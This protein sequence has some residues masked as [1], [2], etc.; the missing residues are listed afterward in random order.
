MRAPR[1]LLLGVVLGSVVMLSASCD[2]ND[3]DERPL[4]QR[5]P[6]A[7]PLL[8]TYYLTQTT[9]KDMRAIKIPEGDA[10]DKDELTLEFQMAGNEL[11]T[12]VEVGVTVGGGRNPVDYDLY[13]RLISP[14]GTASAWKPVDLATGDIYY[15][16]QIVPFLYEFDGENSTGTWKVQLRDPIKDDDGRLLF[17]N[18]TLRINDGEISTV[19][20][21]ASNA[22][23]TASRDATQGRYDV[24]PEVWTTQ[25]TGDFGYFGVN[26]MLLNQFTFTQSFSVRSLTLSFSLLQRE[27]A[28]DEDMIFLVMSPSGNYSFYQLGDSGLSVDVGVGKL[29]SVSYGLPEFLGEPSQGTW[30]VALVDKKIDSNTF[31]LRVNGPV[32]IG[33]GTIVVQ[34]NPITLTL[35]GRTY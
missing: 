32:D 1:L 26:A 4:P 34:S 8:R 13:M 3:E 18:A 35:N 23:E 21:L 2:D 27:E 10:F 17:R 33:G 29:R 20:G 22:N 16:K 28:K 12:D 19:R 6:A 9:P 11:V 15:P 7:T 24:L 30:T 25:F 14:L 31:E 5:A